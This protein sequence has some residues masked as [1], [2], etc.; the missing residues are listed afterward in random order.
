[1]A[2]PDIAEVEAYIRSVAT[3]MGI[4][5]N[6]AVR[7]AKSEGLAPGVWQSNL[8][9]PDGSRE[10]SYGPFQLFEGGGLGNKFKSQYGVSASDP[11]TWKQQVN[12]ALGEAKKGG[13]TPWY[14]AKNAGIGAFEGIRQG[15]AAPAG[16]NRGLVQPEEMPFSPSQG[17]GDAV[18]QA[19]A[20]TF[21]DKMKSGASDFGAAMAQMQPAQQQAPDPIGP[22]TGYA[23]MQLEMTKYLAQN[24]GDPMSLLRKLGLM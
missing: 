11:T 14:G 3:T 4:D 18:A 7:V 9:R 13:W 8:K 20:A 12:F 17:P 15:A 19:P 16:P 5:P 21:M 2:A 23:P 24:Q 1:M 6:V 10:K 22:A